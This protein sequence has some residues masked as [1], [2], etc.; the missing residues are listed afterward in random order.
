MQLLKGYEGKKIEIQVNGHPVNA[1]LSVAW[2]YDDF[3]FKGM[4]RALVYQTQ[5]DIESGLT[6]CV[7]VTVIVS[8]HGLEGRDSLGC[9]F[10]RPSSFEADILQTVSVHEMILNA[11]ADLSKKLV[12]AAAELAKYSKGALNG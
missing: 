4:D 5:K 1:V 7:C 11:G 3:D 10:V 8:A 12:S 6:S 2:E 9:V